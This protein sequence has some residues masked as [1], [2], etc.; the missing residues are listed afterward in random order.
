M[1]KAQKEI[2]QAAKELT[3]KFIETRTISPNN[4]AEIFPVIYNVVN[5]VVPHG[6]AGDE[7]RKGKA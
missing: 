6:E 5:N 4:F 3:A 7:K 2:L 1:D